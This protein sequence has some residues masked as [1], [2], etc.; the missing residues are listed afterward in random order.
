MNNNTDNTSNIDEVIAAGLMA[1]G[2]S[3]IAKSQIL[4]A[5][6]TAI[7]ATPEMRVLKSELFESWNPDQDWLFHA[8]V[9]KVVSTALIWGIEW[10]I[11]G[12]NPH[13]NW[14]W[15]FLQGILPLYETAP[16]MAAR[17]S[18]NPHSLLGEVLAGTG[19]S[20]SKSEAIDSLT[21]KDVKKEVVTK[22]ETNEA[23]IIAVLQPAIKKVCNGRGVVVL[24]PIPAFA[25]RWI[26]NGFYFFDGEPEGEPEEEPKAGK[27]KAGGKREVPTCWP[28]RGQIVRAAA[29]GD[30]DKLRRLVSDNAAFYTRHVSLTQ[31]AN[32][33]E[34]MQ[35]AAAATIFT[36]RGDGLEI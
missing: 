16:L 36:D 35:T 1:G 11:G 12:Q 2:F 10:Y 19:K 9:E 28:F 31:L 34:S 33:V 21:P 7:A 32:K 30:L 26:A 27:T 20:N 13:Q 24:P 23:E 8:V 29:N 3:V 22:K 17:G 5:A 18:K 14:K 6:E 15:E 4:I 25:I